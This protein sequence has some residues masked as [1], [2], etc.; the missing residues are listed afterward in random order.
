M[1]SN[2]QVWFKFPSKIGFIFICDI[3]SVLFGVLSLSTCSSSV[4]TIESTFCITKTTEQTLF[5][6]G[7]TD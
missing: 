4:T 7:E 3:S 2:M 5:E 1:T 6:I